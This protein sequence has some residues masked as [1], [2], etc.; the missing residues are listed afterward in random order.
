MSKHMLSLEQA[1]LA[2]DI[3]ALME[4]H[5]PENPELAVT[6]LK[7]VLESTEEALEESE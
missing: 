7:V 1:N 5:F 4:K 2:F 6:S 3:L